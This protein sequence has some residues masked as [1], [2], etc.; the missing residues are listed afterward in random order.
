MKPRLKPVPLTFEDVEIRLVVDV[1]FLH[2][3]VIGQLLPEWPSFSWILSDRY[4][5]Q[6]MT[7][8]ADVRRSCGPTRR[9][10][11]HHMLCRYDDGAVWIRGYPV[12]LA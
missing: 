9:A 2:L 4:D 6:L 7:T 11:A 8:L 10:V 5:G 1:R 3:L 12:F